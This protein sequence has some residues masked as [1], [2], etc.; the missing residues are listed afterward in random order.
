MK[1]KAADGNGAEAPKKRKKKKISP[2][3][4]MEY[5][6]RKRRQRRML[7]ETK[8]GIVLRDNPDYKKIMEIVKKGG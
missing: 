4:G 3:K 6:N 1:A 8:P 2:E 5:R 7:E